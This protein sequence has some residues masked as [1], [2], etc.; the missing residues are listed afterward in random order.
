MSSSRDRIAREIMG[1]IAERVKT[2]STLQALALQPDLVFIAG[3]LAIKLGDEVIGAT[4]VR[5]APGRR[6]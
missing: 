6:L 2:E 1:A 3:G 4:G 5:G